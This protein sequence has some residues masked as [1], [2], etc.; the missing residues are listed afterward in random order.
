MIKTI[1]VLVSCL[2]TKRDPAKVRDPTVTEPAKQSKNLEKNA[3]K[4]ELT[5]SQKEQEEV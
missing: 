3:P 1:L 2:I 5:C 4:K